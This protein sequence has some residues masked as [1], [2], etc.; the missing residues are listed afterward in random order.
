MKALY[1]GL[2]GFV[3]G[4]II[5]M[6]IQYDDCIQAGGIFVRGLIWFECLK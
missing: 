3:I 5:L 2:A 4:V 6:M 1:I